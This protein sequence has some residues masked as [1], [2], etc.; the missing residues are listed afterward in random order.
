MKLLGH[1]RK[2]HLENL[3]LAGNTDGKRTAETV[4]KLFQVFV[5]IDDRIRTKRGGKWGNDA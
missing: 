3:T 2:E 1:I 5:G 4:I